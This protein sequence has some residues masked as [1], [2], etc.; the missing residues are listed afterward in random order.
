M[1]KTKISWSEFS[2]NPVVGCGKCSPGCL[3]CYAEKMALRLACMEFSRF[4]KNITDKQAKYTSVTDLIGK[5]NGKI[6]C[7]ESALEKPLH[8]K[9][10]R[11][12]FVCS[13]GDLFHPS[14]PFE[15]IKKVMDKIAYC[16]HHSFQILTKRDKRLA[17]FIYQAYGVNG[18][19][20]PPNIKWGVSI[21]TQE[22]ADE[23]LPILARIPAACKFISAEPLL[24]YIDIDRNLLRSFQGIII[25]AESRGRAAGRDCDISWVRHLSEQA[26]IVG[27]K[28]HI[29][30][31]RI[32]GKLVKDI[33]KFPKD[34]QIQ[35]LI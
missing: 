25:G 6:Y 23:K 11:K 7:D 2:W 34:L 13:M 28:R 21:C 29:K 24:D 14:V 12:I 30:Q 4:G 5:W 32:D 10:P 18:Y 17:D 9:K 26:W 27:I 35:E 33:K 3:N 19:G 20:L 31:M 15:F 1:S 22:E 8:W 16:P